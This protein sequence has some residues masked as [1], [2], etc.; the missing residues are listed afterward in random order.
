M[1]QIITAWNLFKG[2]DITVRRCEVGNTGGI[3]EGWCHG[4]YVDGFNAYIYDNLIYDVAWMRIQVVMQT[5]IGTKSI[6]IKM[7]ELSRQWCK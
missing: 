6:Q 5:S 7:M 1:A 3:L 4:I 2:H